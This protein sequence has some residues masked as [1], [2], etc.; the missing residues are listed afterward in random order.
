[1]GDNI[2]QNIT[3]VTHACRK[4]RLKWVATLPRG[5]ISTET[6]SSGMGVER[7]ANNPTL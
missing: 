3:T 1:M 7:G 6:W 2:L 5:D 4:R